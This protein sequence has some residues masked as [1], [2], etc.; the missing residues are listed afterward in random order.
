MPQPW[1]SEGLQAS[2]IP[3][4]SSRKFAASFCPPGIIQPNTLFLHLLLFDQFVEC[5]GNE[6]N[7]FDCS[8][9]PWGSGGC[10]DD[11]ILTV[12]CSNDSIPEPSLTL[13][14]AT[15]SSLLSFLPRPL[16]IP[17]LSLPGLGNI[18]VCLEGE[19]GHEASLL[20]SSEGLTCGLPSYPNLDQNASSSPYSV[21]LSC[22]PESDS[23]ASCA[24][25]LTSSCQV[26]AM[27][28]LCKQK[29]HWNPI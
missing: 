11:D 23:L 13:N 2:A 6:E 7:V 1:T 20:C 28:K 19:G 18:P 17:S 27:L 25:R 12:I 9:S 26:N 22:P 10:E 3:P 14:S 16:H 21:A 8:L 15:T 5:K 29:L 4:W 24:L